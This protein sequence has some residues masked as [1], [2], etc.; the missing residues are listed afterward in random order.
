MAKRIEFNQ[1]GE[2]GVLEYVDFSPRQPA[3]NEVLVANKAIGINYIDTYV[4]S[5]LYP[6]PQL[7][8]SLGTEAAGVVEAVGAKVTHL[9]V[10][11]RVAYCQSPLGAYSQYHTLPAEKVIT[12]PDNVSFEQAAAVMLKGLT[13]YYLLNLTYQVKRDEIILF[14]AAAG[15]VGQIACQWAKAIGA[16]L[17]GTV[18]SDEKIEIA[19]QA[20]AW[21]VINHNKTDIVQ[22]V[23]E[24]TNNQKVNVV[25]DSIGKDMWL[26]SLDCLKR[27]GLM[28]SFGNASGPVTGVDLGILNKKGSLFVTR[29]SLAGYITTLAELQEAGNQLFAMVANGTIKVD[30]NP[31]QIFSLKDVQL[32]HKTIESRKT[33][34]SSLLIP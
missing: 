8:S 14:H 33:T 26:T 1:Y 4:R 16:K 7:P 31:N 10:G 17:I 20:G 21:E 28:V 34:G 13:A 29:P 18:G 2:A 24:L 3:D 25:Y 30:V 5:G 27:R 6:V 11:D 12:L 22:K 15:G 9:K 32:A 23:L 19:K